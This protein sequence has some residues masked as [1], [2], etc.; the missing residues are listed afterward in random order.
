MTDGLGAVVEVAS[1]D[2]VGILVA[3]EDCAALVDWAALPELA[4]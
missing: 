4:G 1:D 3:L 2:V